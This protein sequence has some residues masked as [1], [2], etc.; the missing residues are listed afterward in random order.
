M[1]DWLAVDE[2]IFSFKGRDSVKQYDPK[3]HIN[4]SSKCLI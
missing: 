2:Q 1:E 3:K 4:E